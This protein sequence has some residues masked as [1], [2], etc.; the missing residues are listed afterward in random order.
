MREVLPFTSQEAKTRSFPSG[1]SFW[2]KP[3]LGELMPQEDRTIRLF[4]LNV[5]TSDF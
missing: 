5:Q 2:K 1:T 4:V 3:E